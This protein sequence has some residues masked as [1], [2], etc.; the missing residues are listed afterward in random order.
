MPG[1][2][3]IL[4]NRE[5]MLEESFERFRVATR[6]ELAQRPRIEFVG[7][8]GIDSGGLT[9]VSLTRM[10]RHNG[11]LTIAIYPSTE[12]TSQRI[13]TSKFRAR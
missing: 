11:T 8:P 7:E 13:G 1:V 10:C 2:L 5:V 12:P 6:P 9:K 4:I 3:Q